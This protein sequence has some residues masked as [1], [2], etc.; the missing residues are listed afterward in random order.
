MKGIHL[1]S[2][3]FRH[4]LPK[5]YTS[6]KLAP[7]L[8]VAFENTQYHHQDGGIPNIVIMLVLLKHGQRKDEMYPSLLYKSF[9]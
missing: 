3:N 2:I 6:S 5:K 1:L 4:S 7:Y 9:A 8:E